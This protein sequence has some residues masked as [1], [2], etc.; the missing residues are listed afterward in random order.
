MLRHIACRTIKRL[1]RQ[2][3][4]SKDAAC[5]R[6]PVARFAKKQADEE[7]DDRDRNKRLLKV[8]KSILVAKTNVL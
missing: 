3:F 7:P 5:T 4:S 2:L 1:P 6:F 8:M